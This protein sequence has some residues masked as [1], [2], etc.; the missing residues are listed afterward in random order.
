MPNMGITIFSQ[1]EKAISKFGHDKVRVW[2]NFFRT[3]TSFLFQI[4]VDKL[5][6]SSIKNV[7]KAF[8]FIKTFLYISLVLYFISK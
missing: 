5:L 3:N 4:Q 8:V 7:T 2:Y 6:S 1:Y